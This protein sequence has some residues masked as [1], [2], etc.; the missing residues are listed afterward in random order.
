MAKI[1]T[2]YFEKEEQYGCGEDCMILQS[3]GYHHFVVAKGSLGKGLATIGV[4][5]LGRECCCMVLQNTYN[6]PVVIRVKKG[7]DVV[8]LRVEAG[9]WEKP[10]SDEDAK[11]LLKLLAQAEIYASRY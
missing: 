9:G 1:N 4:E 5:D 6:F 10:V 7:S 3:E 11:W 8:P 2:E